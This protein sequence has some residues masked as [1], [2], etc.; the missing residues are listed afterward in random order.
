[1]LTAMG[2]ETDRIIGLELGA[3]DYLPKPF[4]P[5][6]LLARIRAVLRRT[7]GARARRP[8]RRRARYRFAGWRLEPGRRRLLDPD[9]AEVPLTGGEYDLLAATG[10]ARQPGADPRH[11]ARPAARPPGRARSTARSTSPS[12]GCAASSS[13]T[14]AGHRQLIKT[15]RGGG[16]VFAC[17]VERE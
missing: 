13:A 11:A 9:G 7:D 15:V 5:R 10:R 3:D 17:E 16:Y 1:M 8:R 4:N 2:E 6:E 14:G 12:A